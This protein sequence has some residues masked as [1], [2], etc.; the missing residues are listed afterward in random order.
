VDITIDENAEKVLSARHDHNHD[1]VPKHWAQY[2]IIGSILTRKVEENPNEKPNK[3]NRKE[4]ALISLLRTDDRLWLKA[5][6]D[7]PA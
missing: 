3:L 7:F 4:S 1:N 5:I 6:H 2:Q